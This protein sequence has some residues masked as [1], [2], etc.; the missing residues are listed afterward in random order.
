MLIFCFLS[1]AKENHSEVATLLLSHPDIDVN[2][3]SW[4]EGKTALH[5]A[6]NAGHQDVAKVL[7]SCPQTDSDI[8]DQNYA[9]AVDL[10]PD[11]AR[12]LHIAGASLL[13]FALDIAR[14]VRKLSN[15]KVLE[16]ERRIQTAKAAFHTS[17]QGRKL[18]IQYPRFR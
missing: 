12:I 1:A 15:L 5:F 10:A 2:V 13:A 8:L 7:L 9:S 16:A 4:E 18:P 3:K 17:T 6:C 11:I 14:G